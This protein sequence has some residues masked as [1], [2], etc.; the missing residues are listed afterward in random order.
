MRSRPTDPRSNLGRRDFLRALGLTGLGLALPDRILADPYAPLPAD[1][2]TPI[3]RRGARAIRVQGRV[4]SGGRGLGGVGVTDGLQVVATDGDGRFQIATTEDRGFVGLSLPRGYEIPRNDTGTARLYAPLQPNAAG[5]AEVGFDLQR[6]NS[7][8]EN[9]TLLLLAD[10]QTQTAQE[11][12]WF[13]QQTVPDVIETTSAVGGD[14]IGIAD[15]DI[16]YDHLEFYPEYERAVGRM[17]IPF[18]QC[19]GN[20][21]L[22][23]GNPTDLTSTRTFQSHFGPRYY[24]FNRGAI[25]YVVLDDVFWYGDGYIGYL[26]ED[27][28][29]WLANDLAL[30]EP[31]RPVIV[32]THIPAM[33]GSYVRYDQEKPQVGM[34]ITNREALYRLLEPYDAHILTGHTHENEHIYEG[35]VHEHVSGAVC[36]GWWSGPICWDGCPSGYSVYEARGEEITWRYKSTGLPADHQM[37]IYPQGSDPTA[38]DEMVVNIWDWNRDWSAVWYEDGER[39]GPLAQRRGLDPLSVELHTGPELPPHR[40]WV[41]PRPTLH[42]FYAPVSPGAREIRVEATDGFGRVYTETLRLG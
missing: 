31:G 2:T 10:P 28:L 1:L 36:G 13:H 21:D 32:A 12:E 9:H 30:V 42:L 4:Q 23:Q 37:R 24:S 20:H 8:D 35:G 33:G 40:P 17:G 19:V 18:F 14:V 3:F 16:M 27:Q 6:L 41:D 7:A 11:L 25:H 22:D 5:E 34:A 38:P 15:G 29:G 39:K 26:A